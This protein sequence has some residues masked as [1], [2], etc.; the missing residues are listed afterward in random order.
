MILLPRRLLHDIKQHATLHYPEEGAGLLLGTHKD[1]T[2]EVTQLMPLP[3]TFAPEARATRYL[4]RPEDMLEAEQKAD[5]MDL[6]ILGV[7]HSHP[8]HPARP[9]AF[10]QR[11]ALPWYSYII[12][13]VSETAAGDVRSWRLM[14]ERKFV[15]E[16]IEIMD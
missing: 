12:T 5:E 1:D 14:E 9:S 7:F 8:D 6:D 3:N 15:E 2:R 16:E 13:S 11:N 10:D 4:I